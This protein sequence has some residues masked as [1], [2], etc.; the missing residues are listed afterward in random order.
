MAETVGCHLIL[1]AFPAE[2]Q[3][4]DIAQNTSPPSSPKA[5]S[6]QQ[7]TVAYTFF[8]GKQTQ[9]QAVPLARGQVLRWQQQ[10]SARPDEA[11]IRS[12]AAASAQIPLRISCA[13]VDQPPAAGKK[14]ATSGKDSTNS[15]A[16][17][18]A[19][20]PAACDMRL[21]CTALLLGESICELSL[22]VGSGETSSGMPAVEAVFEGFVKVTIRLEAD[23]PLLTS[24]L[25][26]FLNPLILRPRAAR[27]LPDFPATRD[28][29]DAMCA[30]PRIT[31][32]LPSTKSAA[33]GEERVH[34]GVPG[35]WREGAGAHAKSHGRARDGKPCSVRDV[36]FQGLPCILFAADFGPHL[37]D[38]LMSAPLEVKVHDRTPL[39]SE[40]D[41]DQPVPDAHG[42][43][44]ISL[45][46]LCIPASSSA[47]MLLPLKLKI[48]APIAAKPIPPPDGAEV[49]WR[50]RPG[51][52]MEA[53]A[54]I[55]FAVD[56][57]HPI[58]Q[59]ADTDKRFARVVLVLEYADSDP[60]RAIVS[61]VRTAN[62]K[63]LGLTGDRE[64]ILRTLGTMMIDEQ[65]ARDPQLDVVTGF[66]VIDSAMRMIVLEGLAKGAMRLIEELAS[67]Y[68]SKPKRKRKRKL[69][70]NRELAYTERLYGSLGA[71]I[72]LVKLR[73]QLSRIM[74][75][76]RTAAA[77]RLKPECVEC[78]RR[79]SNLAA[80]TWERQAASMQLF[81]TSGMV[82]ALYRKY[83]G[84]LTIDD[85]M[86]VTISE[87]ARLQ[88]AKEE[89]DE[90][91]EESEEDFRA[92]FASIKPKLDA[93]NNA[94]LQERAARDAKRAE[95]DIHAENLEAL[96]AL[97]TAN[98][99]LRAAFWHTID[100]LE[101]PPETY[102]ESS[103][104]ELAAHHDKPFV[105]P[106]P[107]DPA[108]YFTHPKKPTF[109]RVAE[110]AEPWEEN[111]FANAVGL[112][113]D[114]DSQLQVPF[115]TIVTAVH[116]NL[117]GK[118]PEY[119]KTVH[120]FGDGLQKE[121]EAAK[122]REVEEWKSKVVVAD[123]NFHAVLPMRRISGALDKCRTLLADKPKKKGLRGK[124][125]LQ[126]PPSSM[127]SLEP[128]DGPLK[129]VSTVA[130]G[131]TTAYLIPNVDFKHYIANVPAKVT[132]KPIV[133]LREEEKTRAT[134]KVQKPQGLKPLHVPVKA[135]PVILRE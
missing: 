129:S 75:D 19:S 126:P 82:G 124:V 20:P 133:P 110:L 3:E 49:D 90:E 35:K 61:A 47:H 97:E 80:V 113:R 83:G 2:Q 1:E 77:G 7:L 92:H 14:T 8:E 27:S 41:R 32:R 112:Q 130:R 99:H 22:D 48:K 36:E 86:G 33:R 87:A 65:L 116:G 53:G 13:S 42:V 63:A 51:L 114:S 10:L 98:A 115:K 78:L 106:A 111:A 95:R 17:T 15:N 73:D 93:K 58:C 96:H 100:K 44:L 12:I 69:L 101:P 5:G 88:A 31:Y 131:D 56:A 37:Y 29:I 121:M 134:F 109:A 54:Y 107:K 70:L 84:E 71:D 120:S 21:D 74:S 62:I 39:P 68:I 81:P 79:I 122:Q 127:Y 18:E 4:A 102:V 25:A 64:H 46:A 60:L 9:G 43:A 59:P 50:W 123:T 91:D 118:D 34:E 24:S 117:F 45:S 104:T 125:A 72:Q 66:Q 108:E 132:R 38:Q 30:L 103:R 11:F 26:A 55:S 76:P 85:V 52:F 23:Q 16:T 128:F 28:I 89:E 67:G 40:T 105:W 57:M 6:Q 135:S 119:F 94:Y